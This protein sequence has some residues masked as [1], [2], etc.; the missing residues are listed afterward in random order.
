MAD[1]KFIPCRHRPLGIS[2]VRLG[3][4]EAQSPVDPA[5]HR[6]VIFVPAGFLLVKAVLAHRGNGLV[7][8]SLAV[9]GIDHSESRG[10]ESD[11][12]PEIEGGKECIRRPLRLEPGIQMD[13]VLRDP[14]LIAV[15]QVDLGMCGKIVLDQHFSTFIELSVVI[16]GD[17]DIRLAGILREQM[18]LQ[19]GITHDF[20]RELLPLRVILRPDLLRKGLFVDQIPFIIC[21][22][23][24]M[25]C[26][27]LFTGS[28]F[29]I[30]RIPSRVQ[31]ALC[32]PL[33]YNLTV[34]F[35]IR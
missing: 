29:M 16:T 31:T 17:D 27:P 1:R 4:L 9:S 35:F 21:S 25:R 6:P 22:D 10:A 7:I 24:H 8:R 14:V 2:A 15:Q 19:M 34:A 3:K 33:S 26:A 11:H 28:P 5:P 32:I 20:R 13:T 23:C 12:I 30:L 18:V